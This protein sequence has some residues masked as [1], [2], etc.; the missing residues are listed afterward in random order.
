[1]RVWRFGDV[2]R[3]TQYTQRLILYGYSYVLRQYARS[4]IGCAA[5]PRDNLH[6]LINV[7]MAGAS[8]ANFNT[9]SQYCENYDL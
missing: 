6:C 8:C 2:D 9:N 1:M 7:Q 5:V 4:V 3:P